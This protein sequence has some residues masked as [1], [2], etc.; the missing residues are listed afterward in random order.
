MFCERCGT[1]ISEGQAQCPNCQFN[2]NPVQPNVYNTQ[3]VN[4]AGHNGPYAPAGMPRK[5]K[6]NGVN[7]LIIGGVA[8]ALLAVILIAVFSG[9][10]ASPEK[11]LASMEKTNAKVVAEVASEAYGSYLE[12]LE[13]SLAK[14]D[15]GMNT[16]TEIKLTVEQSVLSSMIAMIVG[17]DMSNVDLSWL[18]NVLLRF[19]V[20]AKGDQ[21]AISCGVGINDT[22]LATLAAMTDAAE[23][24]IFLAVPELNE[25]YIYTGLDQ[26]NVD[27]GTMTV[28]QEAMEKLAEELPSEKEVKKMLDAYL[29]I[30][31]SYA[32]EVEKLQETVT[33]GDQTKE[34]TVLQAKITEKKLMELMIEIVKTAQEDQTLKALVCAIENYSSAVNKA[35]YGYTYTTQEAYPALLE[36]LAYMIEEL[37]AELEYADPENYILLSNYIQSGMI[38]GRKAELFSEGESEGEIGRFLFVPA[39]NGGVFEAA[40]DQLRIDGVI[41]GEEMDIELTVEGWHMLTI[42]AK[43]LEIE[44]NGIE[45]QLRLLPSST[46]LNEICDS[47]GIAL[48][49]YASEDTYIQFVF[50]TDKTSNPVGIDL[51]IGGNT[52][53]G[54]TISVKEGKYDTITT[55][56]NAIGVVSDSDLMSWVAG[57]QFQQLIGNMQTAGV[58]NAYVQLVQQLELML[59]MQGI[60]P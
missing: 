55:P 11:R 34:M 27:L 5:K 26:A 54:V 10:F 56:E 22:V 40:A 28:M 57:I 45:G 31:L 21:M 4:Y 17:E 25:Q 47:L 60:L 44:D 33:V 42:S 52:L 24:R 18:S 50:V 59:Q 13:E 14:L 53:A 15:K 8:V 46:M 49:V 58:P 20:D 43:D 36:E 7:L 3:P 12:S 39:K 19:D 16:Q 48:P 41:D 37:E 35:Q 6:S 1:K 30:V 29:Q 23:N 51:V 2:P 32:E 9:V 38:V